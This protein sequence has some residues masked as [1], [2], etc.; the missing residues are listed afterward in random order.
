[1]TKNTW[2]LLIILVGLHLLVLVN[3]LFTDW[4]EMYLWPYLML[5]GWLPYKDIAIAHTPIL[6][7]LLKTFYVVFG[8][9]V[10]QLKIVTWLLIGLTDLGLFLIA[11]KNFGVKIAFGTLILYVPLQIY[12]QGNG[13]WFDLLLA[14]L[15]LTVFWQIKE[16]RYLISG[17]VWALSFLTKQTAVWFLPPLIFSLILTT[18]K[19]W[20]VPISRFVIGATCVFCATLVIFA[21]LGVLTDFVYWAGYFGLTI[22]P[23][24]EGQIAFPDV[25]TT[26]K[27]LLAFTP[28]VFLVRKR[29]KL[30]EV[31]M[32]AIFLVLGTVPRWAL[33]HFQPAL[34]FLAFFVSLLFYDLSKKRQYVFVILYC[35]AI[36]LLVTRELLRNWQM[37][38]R[39][40]DASTI[41]IGKYIRSVVEAESTIYVLNY[42]EHAYAITE[43]LPATRPWIPHLAWYMDMP[44][45][46][47]AMIAGLEQTRPKYIL[48]KPYSASGLAAYRPAVLDSYISQNY[49]TFSSVENV[50][51]LR[52]R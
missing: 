27:A 52:Q 39:F 5:K 40:T 18:K 34:P 41:A 22:L 14:P 30:L 37:G 35:A 32:W 2:F 48:F 13:L 21:K 31:G 7:W 36:S 20:F 4:P 16:K 42:W 24:S 25:W 38:N 29:V 45:V 9:G 11:K 6:L 1:M 47:E 44:G 46:Q 26:A 10:F 8:I 49:Y 3:S 50:D 51:I 28:L 17:I 19:Q 33:F 15:G 23:R 12:Y 43:T